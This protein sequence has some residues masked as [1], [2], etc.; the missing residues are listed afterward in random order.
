MCDNHSG[1]HHHHGEGGCHCHEHK[2][3]NPEE[4][5]A[6]LG[7]MLDH[8]RHHA[9]D[10]HALFHDLEAQGKTEAAELLHQALHFFEDGNEKLAAALKAL[11]VK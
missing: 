8:N 6:M 4:T 1:H 10:L 5:L 3:Q 9:E 11:E 2:A 7:Y